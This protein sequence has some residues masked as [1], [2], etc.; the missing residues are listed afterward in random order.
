MSHS[1]Q[2]VVVRKE[3]IVLLLVK[4]L[5]LFWLY[6]YGLVPVG[7]LYFWPLLIIDVSTR[8]IHSQVPTNEY[9]CQPLSPMISIGFVDVCVVLGMTH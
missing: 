6:S 8:G 7:V 4:A 1:E 2:A 3:R 9:L 5:F